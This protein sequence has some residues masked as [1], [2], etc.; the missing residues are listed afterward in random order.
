MS[1][2]LLRWCSTRER[3]TVYDVLECL[4][5]GM[6]EDEILEDF[7]DLEREDIRRVWRLL[8]TLNVVLCPVG[9]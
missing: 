3:I 1:E 4:A 6:T 5:S 8:P 7:P 9:P 2:R